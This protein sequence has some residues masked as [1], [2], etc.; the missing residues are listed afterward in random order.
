MKQVI[1][2]CSMFLSLAI[3]AQD[4]DALVKK[5]KAKYEKVNDYEA[6]GKMKTNVSFM[7]V[8]EAK[9]KIYYK[10]PDKLKIKNENGISFVPKG[11][12]N[13]N[14][15]N[16][17]GVK[18]YTA[19]DAGSGTVDGVTVKI[20]K[21]I[22]EDEASGI[23]LS[24]LYIDEKKE[25]VVKTKTTTRD[26]GTYELLMQYGKYAAW[27]LPDK[28]TFTFST[29]DYKL[30]KG[31]TIDYDNGSG[32]GQQTKSKTGKVE[33]TYSSYTINKGLDDSI[34]K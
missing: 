34:F 23:V 8:P 32:N 10:K 7:K 11:S 4:A 3:C 30:P 13:I 5:I 12:V 29:K 33:I 31:V 15:G 21:I 19:I 24:T 26:N 2:V 1:L 17:F 22:P 18:S 20:I 25:L 6:S 28:A 9:V 14:M 16:I 27:A